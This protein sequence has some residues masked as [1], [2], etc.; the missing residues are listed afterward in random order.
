MKLESSIGEKLTKDT[1]AVDGVFIEIGSTPSTEIF[2]ELNLKTD[3]GGYIIIDRVGRTSVKGV[4]AAGDGAANPFKQ[5]ITATADGV[6][7]AK[8]AY[9]FLTLGK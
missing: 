3:E 1:L 5:T 6:L 2:Q 9:D 7:A 8:A 4:Y